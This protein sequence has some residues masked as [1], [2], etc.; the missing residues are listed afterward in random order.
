M[1]ALI[2]KLQKEANAYSAYVIPEPSTALLDL[3]INSLK[4]D[5]KKFDQGGLLDSYEVNKLPL[6]YRK[7]VVNAFNTIKDLEFKRN[8]QQVKQR[9]PHHDH[10]RKLYESIIAVLTEIVVE[11]HELYQTGSEQEFDDN[12]TTVCAACQETAA[13]DYDVRSEDLKLYSDFIYKI[14]YSLAKLPFAGADKWV[15]AIKFLRHNRISNIFESDYFLTQMLLQYLYISPSSMRTSVDTIKKY[16]E[17]LRLNSASIP[18]VLR[19]DVA[20]TSI[21]VEEIKLLSKLGVLYYS[22]RSG[23][24]KHTRFGE[25]IIN[26]SPPKKLQFNQFCAEVK[27][28]LSKN[29]AEFIADVKAWSGSSIDSKELDAFVDTQKGLRNQQKVDQIRKLLKSE[30]GSDLLG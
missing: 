17:I 9:E 10:L 24:I 6:E 28:I 4:E 1:N 25:F 21:L 14:D 23:A 2:K 8:E 12:I 11:L 26:L 15:E 27:N 30:Y 29:S 7:A 13:R 22:A 18:W 16:E 19:F 5:I 3:E 20:W